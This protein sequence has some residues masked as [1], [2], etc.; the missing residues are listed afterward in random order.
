[1]SEN[2]VQVL[3]YLSIFP[4]LRQQPV[5]HVVLSGLA[6]PAEQYY[7]LPAK[8]RRREKGEEKRW[9]RWR[10]YVANLSLHVCA[11][12]DWGSELRLRLHAGGAHCFVFFVQRR[13]EAKIT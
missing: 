8:N 5:G 10:E 1:M 11:Y 3:Q 7:H 6:L 4:Q 13:A 2:R 12:L 9:V